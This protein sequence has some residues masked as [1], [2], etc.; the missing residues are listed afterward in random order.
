MRNAKS[1]SIWI[2]FILFVTALLWYQPLN[3]VGTL[4]TMP[5]GL[6]GGFLIAL[7]YGAYK[8]FQGR[9]KFKL[10]PDLRLR[11]FKNSQQSADADLQAHSDLVRMCFGDTQ[12]VERL[13]RHEQSRRPDLTRPQATRAARDR[14]MHD[15]G[16]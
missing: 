4:I 13:I 8:W 12:K 11:N 15:R 16:R 3:S 7:A 1:A 9:R 14:L 2:I 6:I 5:V 10:P